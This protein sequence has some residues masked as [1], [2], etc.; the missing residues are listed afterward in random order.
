MNDGRPVPLGLKA[1]ETFPKQ[2]RLLKRSEYLRVQGS[3]RKLQTRSLL[4]L[5]L[6]NRLG[7]TRLGIA[8]SKKYGPSVQRNRLKR[9][10]REAFRRHKEL[11]PASADL[12]VIPKRVS[13]ELSYALIVD[14]LTDLARR[15]T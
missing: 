3:G 8:V 11:F 7:R 10:V 9:L 5:R 4:I 12:V 15:R 14:E 13:H 6:P 2:S 1:N